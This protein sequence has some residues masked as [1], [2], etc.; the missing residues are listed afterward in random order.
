M[1][2]RPG[3][4]GKPDPLDTGGVHGKAAVRHH[5]QRRRLA[6]LSGDLAEPGG[7]ARRGVGIAVALDGK[8]FGVGGYGE[9]VHAVIVAAL[10][11][12][13]AFRPGHAVRHRMRR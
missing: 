8:G 1:F 3:G 7:L 11:G 4:F 9:R 5:R 2:V 10:C 13:R 6:K 12:S